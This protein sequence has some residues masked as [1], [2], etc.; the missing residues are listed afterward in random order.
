[1][2]TREDVIRNAEQYINI[3]PWHPLSDKHIFN[4]ANPKQ[5]FHS[6]FTVGEDDPVSKVCRLNEYD[7]IPY[8]Y[9]KP[10]GDPIPHPNAIRQQIENGTCPGGWD[11]ETG[12]GTA[13]WHAQFG[14]PAMRNLAGIDCSQYVMRC[15]GFQQRGVNGTE[16]GTA[17]LPELCLEIRKDALK[18]GDILL[19]SGHVRIFHCWA[20]RVRNNAWIYEAA[21]A[22][23]ET[24][25]QRNALKRPFKPDDDQGCVG[26]WKRGWENIYTPYSP[27]PQFIDFTPGATCPPV[28][29]NPRPT[30]SVTCV[31]SGEIEITAMYLDCAEVYMSSECVTVR[32][33]TG[34]GTITIGGT[35]A[36]FIPN[37]DLS[38]GR[39]RVDVIAINRVQGSS[40]CDR[41]CWVFDLA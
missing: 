37:S 29:K 27:F 32:W 36:T 38:F 3:Q 20:D 40:F 33:R 23:D 16:Y 26:R 1:M 28:V 21:G 24:P 10:S 25:E 30:I 15:W 14:A 39:H 8:V 4:A 17:H 7:V 18:K 12:Y 5:T 2:I 41:F 9:G 31:G 6:S 13:R 35:R 34:S 22:R 19:K 11:K